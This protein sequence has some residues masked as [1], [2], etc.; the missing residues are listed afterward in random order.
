MND[1]SLELFLAAC[2]SDGPIR[3]GVGQRRRDLESVTLDRSR[4]PFLVIGR[5]TG[6]ADLVLDHWQVS[7]RHAYL[8]ARSRDA[9]TA[10]TWGAGPAPMVG[11]RPNDRGGSSPAGLD[12]DWPV[13]AVRPEWPAPEA[14]RPSTPPPGV[15]WELPNR[16]IGQALWRMDRYLALI[17]RSPACKIR[18]DRARRVAVPLQRGA[19]QARALGNRPARRK[20]RSTVNDQKIRCILDRGRRRAEGGPARP[21]G[22]GTTQHRS[23]RCPSVRPGLTTRRSLERSGRTCRKCLPRRSGPLQPAAH[24]PGRTPRTG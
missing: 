9:I 2:G 4:Q 14:L 12:P 11:T 19:H 22:F 8:P 20:R 1:P 18:L 5:R 24:H 17:G 13:S 23:V 16:A 6:I 10:S 3:L 15:T 21:Q 7:R